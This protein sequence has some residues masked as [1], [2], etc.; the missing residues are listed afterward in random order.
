MTFAFGHCK[1]ICP[2]VVH[3]S[4]R[5]QRV[6]ADEARGEGGAG[7][8]VLVVTLDPWRDTPSRLPHLSEQW[9]LATDG[10]A[11]SGSVQAVTELLDGLDVQ[12]QL[13]MATGDIVQPALVFLI[14]EDGRIV[15][16]PGVRHAWVPAAEPARSG[17]GY[18]VIVVDQDSP[19]APFEP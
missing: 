8:V 13:D 2:L 17:I 10:L 11:V 6:L 12:R 19:W 5:A 4:V 1:T 9:E 15:W 7:P 18:L 16:I 14:D 3:E